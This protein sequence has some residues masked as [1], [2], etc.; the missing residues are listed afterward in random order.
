MIDTPTISRYTTNTESATIHNMRV[1]DAAREMGKSV[2]YI[3]IGLQRGF[4]PFGTAQ[5]I[6]RK[7]TIHILY[8]PCPILPVHR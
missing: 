6:P 3:R 5:I 7:Y 1:Q 2:A 8:L 4:L